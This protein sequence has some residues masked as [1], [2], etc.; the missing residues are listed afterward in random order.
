MRRYLRLYGHFL[1]LSF[2]RSAQFRLDF[3]FRVL[4][5]VVW[6]VHYLGMFA[7]FAWHAPTLGGWDVHQLRVFTGAIF[8][9]DALQMTLVANGAWE[10]P[11]AIN[12]GDLDYH[13]VRPVSTLFMVS[14]RDIAVSSAVNLLIAMAI[15]G[16]S[17]GVYPRPLDAGALVGFLL[18]L[19]LGVV[20]HWALHLLALSTAFW[21][22]STKGLRDLFWTSVDF[23]FRPVGVYP[24]W[25]RR[26]LTTVLPVG[27]IV[28]FPC[29]V[30]FEGPSFGVVAH[31]VAAAAGAFGVLLV[32][33]RRGLRAY[34]SA[35]S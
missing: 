1:R 34:G 30:L 25:M 17:L 22:Q 29:R 9:V 2:A 19:P 28:S 6:N 32:V 3:A 5:D 16:W 33:W 7:L 4:M 26:L 12:R 11:F 21:T 27:V 20:I 31:M 13:L 8:V 23:A 14:L 15:L 10:L 18:L 24:S 35:S